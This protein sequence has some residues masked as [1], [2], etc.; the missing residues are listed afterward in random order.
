M[1]AKS[2]T[3]SQGGIQVHTMASDFAIIHIK[4]IAKSV[5]KAPRWYPSSYNGF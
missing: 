4:A 2:V 1:I 5:I 3:K